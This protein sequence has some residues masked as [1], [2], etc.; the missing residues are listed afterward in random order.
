[1]DGL[2]PLNNLLGWVGAPNA[3]CCPMTCQWRTN[4]KQA[5]SLVNQWKAR[6]VCTGR[7]MKWKACS[8]D[9]RGVPRFN[10]KESN[11]IFNGKP[12]PNHSLASAQLFVHTSWWKIQLEL[13]CRGQALPFFDKKN[14]FSE[15][16]MHRVIGGGPQLLQKR[17]EVMDAYSL[18][19]HNH[20]ALPPNLKDFQVCYL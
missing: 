12:K 14:L 1:M 10:L 13:T 16:I 2:G 19:Q 15:A 5:C 17:A 20:P 18:L 9:T 7:S 3:F 4:Q 8:Y 6:A 11:R